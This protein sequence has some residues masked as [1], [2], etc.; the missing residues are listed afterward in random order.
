MNFSE[1]WTSCTLPLAQ[2]IGSNPWNQDIFSWPQII[3]SLLIRSST[4]YSKIL[5]TCIE[6]TVKSWSLL[7]CCHY[8][9]NQLYNVPSH[10]S[11]KISNTTLL[12]SVLFQRAKGQR[13]ITG[14]FLLIGLWF[15][16][17]GHGSTSSSLSTPSRNHLC[18]KHTTNI[19]GWA[20]T[21]YLQLKL[22][23][24]DLGPANINSWAQHNTYN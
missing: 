21:Q 16:I 17:L 8:F 14:F 20:S 2:I 5:Q 1:I 12:F 18:K 15:S 13:S 10:C 23:T 6:K 19:N 4:T 24:V 7:Q 22:D 3:C 9:D 11:K